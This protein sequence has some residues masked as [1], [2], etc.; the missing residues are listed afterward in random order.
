MQ[1]L[2]NEFARVC[3]KNKQLEIVVFQLRDRVEALE[4]E[5]KIREER[6]EKINAGVFASLHQMIKSELR[7][8]GFVGTCKDRRNGK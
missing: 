8:I 2:S 3:D 4:S 7:E 5:I 6:L 1:N